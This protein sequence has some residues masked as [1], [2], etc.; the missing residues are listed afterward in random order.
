MA[1]ASVN[2][3]SQ[4]ENW[5]DR[6]ARLSTRLP[7]R[8]KLIGGIAQGLMSATAALIAYL[9]TKP[10]GL[11]EGFWGSITAIAVVQS[12]LSASRTSAR[13]QF[14]GAAIGGLISAIIVTLAGQHLV[15]Y[16]IAVILAMLA[17]WVFNVSSAARLA[18]STTTIILL[19]P[20]Q[21]PPEW[22]VV[23]RIAEV[24][25][26][27]AVGFATVWLVNK[28]ETTVSGRRS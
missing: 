3:V 5:T 10:L 25:W 11:R 24:G 17:C 14:V 16:A 26:G 21:G 12:E 13:D 9:P 8:A 2:K 15:T 27:V 20:H 7:A 19:V 18:G 22:M 6:L 1:T 4:R 23:S 28:I